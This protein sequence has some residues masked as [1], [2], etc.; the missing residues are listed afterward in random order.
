MRACIE[1]YGALVWAL[2]RR[3]SEGR[4]D[5]EDAVQEIFTELWRSAARFDPSIASEAAFIVVIAR[6]RLIDRRRRRTRRL[7]REP[8][9]EIVLDPMS[10]ER[11]ELGHD[12]RRAAEALASLKP[13]QRRMLTLSLYEGLSHGEIAKSTGSPLGT[14]KANIRRG[15]LA[16]RRALGVDEP[17]IDRQGEGEADDEPGR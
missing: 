13:E 14:V 17:T 12:A 2:A 7:D 1:R 11:P 9:P 15:L 6:R 4:A 5:A 3:G 16:V 8:L 10:A